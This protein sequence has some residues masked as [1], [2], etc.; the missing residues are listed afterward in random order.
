MVG[1]WY[2]HELSPAV[3]TSREKDSWYLFAGDGIFNPAGG[4]EL[5]AL[6]L[7][8][9]FSHAR[10]V[11]GNKYGSSFSIGAYLLRHSGSFNDIFNL[12]NNA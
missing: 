7:K 1:T 3:V 4:S 11:N 2:P 5:I 9:H 12:N 8:R 6:S 10:Y